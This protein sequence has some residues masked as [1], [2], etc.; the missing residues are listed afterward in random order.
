MAKANIRDRR[1]LARI[2][3][4]EIFAGDAMQNAA[5]AEVLHGVIL[6]SAPD[7]TG[8]F[9][10]ERA[11]R[12]VGEVSARFLAPQRRAEELVDQ[13][14]YGGPAERAAPDPTAGYEAFLDDIVAAAEKLRSEAR[15]S[16]GPGDARLRGLRQ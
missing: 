7:T 14:R 5:P 10:I 12:Q 4:P 6:V 13:G 8:Q 9:E 15:P 16:P 2:Y 1:S 11:T 3:P